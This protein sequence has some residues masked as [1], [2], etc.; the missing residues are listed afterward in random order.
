MSK[1]KEAA[2]KV[3]KVRATKNTL[4]R[5]SK[6]AKIMAAMGAMR[7]V[8]FRQSIRLFGEAEAEYKANGR[9]VFGK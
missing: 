6:A 4:L 9:L 7:G 1:K 8:N 2:P 5:V 3:K